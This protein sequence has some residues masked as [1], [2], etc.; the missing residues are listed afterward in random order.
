MTHPT[1]RPLLHPLALLAALLPLLVACAGFDPTQLIPA[2]E[3][4]PTAEATATAAPAIPTV[5]TDATTAV[6]TAINGPL[7]PAPTDWEGLEGWLTTLW[8]GGVNPA[9][10]RAALRQSGMQRGDD[11]WRAADFDG[12]LQDDWA[13]VLYDPSLPGV[14]F[15]AAGDLWIVNGD[16]VVFRYYPAPSSDIYEFLAPTVVDVADLTGDGLPELVTDARMCGAHTCF[17]NF[18]VIGQ[19]AAG[20]ADLVRRAPAGE[21]DPGNTINIS[22]PE[23]RLAD[24]DG[25]GVAEL[26]VRGGSIGSAGAGVVRPRTEV[27][28]WDGAAVSLAETALDPTDYRHHI[29]YEANDL[30]A[31]G[32]LDGALVL[33]EAAITDGALRND[34]FA[35]VPEA[36]Y[37]DVSRFAAFRLALIDL[38]HGDS[39]RAAGRLAWLQTNHPDAPATTAA[40]MLI[41]G[42]TDEDGLPALCERIETTLAAA[43]SP[44]GALAD[45][46]YG[47][48]SLTA[49]DFCP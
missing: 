41:G 44:T 42:W 23:A 38:R 16:G 20:L 25:D 28:R 8:R 2:V 45:M 30:L 11:D 5:A 31:A 32:D 18:R 10:V 35:H 19:T 17:G 34:G 47:N 39:E 6:P 26:V 37:A 13:L 7:A 22:Y 3:I 40:A 27:W 21:S 49:A 48:P 29:L 46:G 43:D 24:G 9:A 33:Y 36:V 12:D 14:P 4:G 1:R 15:G